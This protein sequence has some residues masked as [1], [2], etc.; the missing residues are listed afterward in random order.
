MKFKLLSESTA[1]ENPFFKILDRLYRLPDGSE[2]HFYVKEEPDTCC[3]LA[4]TSDGKYIVTHQYRVGSEEVLVEICGGRLEDEDQTDADILKRMQHEL[5][6]ETGYSGEFTKVGILPGGPY[7]TR[8]VHVFIADNCKK[9]G[10]QEL[11]ETEFIEVELIPED[12]MKNVLFSGK[13]SSCAAGLLAWSH[14]HISL[15]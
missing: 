14:L 6:E 11:D 3:V 2:H 5:R 7:T 1:Y 13:S 4:R 8:K 12:E 9:I 10:E 15:S